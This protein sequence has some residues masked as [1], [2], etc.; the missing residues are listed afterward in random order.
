MS[1]QPPSTTFMAEEQQQ[2][3]VDSKDHFDGGA[4]AQGGHV[5]GDS[6][7]I[8]AIPISMI[9][10]DNSGRVPRKRGRPRKYGPPLAAVPIAPSPPLPTSAA[11]PPSHSSL[12][13]HL[14]PAPYLTS[15]SVS[16]IP[17]SGGS[18]ASS[19]HAPAGGQPSSFSSAKHSTTTAPAAYGASATPVAAATPLA[20]VAAPAV[21]STNTNTT[22]T[23][24]VVTTD[25]AP[26]G[27]F[28]TPHAPGS[29]AAPTAPALAAAPT[30][31]AR[32]AAAGGSASASRG[33]GSWAHHIIIV[34]PGEL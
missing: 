19:F 13:P 9:P 34:K 31:R 20:G 11:A 30:A 21:A 8:L 3:D 32:P 22:P 16:L 18:A 7:P 15:A 17:R 33:D 12:F 27:T 10:P 5:V 28:T 4:V 1:D 29:S 24:A 2:M 25:F 6:E 23:P 14:E 26:A